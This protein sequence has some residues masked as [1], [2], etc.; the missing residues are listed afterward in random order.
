MTRL[1]HNSL[2]VEW[3][4][5]RFMPSQ[6]WPHSAGLSIFLAPWMLLYGTRQIFIPLSQVLGVIDVIDCTH[7]RTGTPKMEEASYG[8]RKR[9]HNINVQTEFDP[10]YKI[11]EVLAEWPGSV[12]DGKIFSESA[13][14]QQFERN[15][16]PAGCHLLGNS[17]YPSRQYL[18]RMPPWGPLTFDPSLGHSQT[19]TSESTE[20]PW[21]ILW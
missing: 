8:N 4:P 1:C 16:I 9:H 2:S 21:L 20:L 12:H 18:V 5:K 3:F 6:V 15:I 17:G 13:V 19:T 11:N 14:T 7:V 10:N